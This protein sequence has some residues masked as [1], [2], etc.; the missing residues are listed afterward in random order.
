[1]TTLRVGVI[2]GGLIAQVVHLPEVA[3]LPERFELSAIAEPNRELGRAL[4]AKYG[5]ATTHETWQSL[6][7]SSEVDAVIVCAPN[8]L[9]AQILDAALDRGIPSL[10]E[11]PVCLT[12]ADAARLFERS[13]REGTHMQV[14]YMKRFDAA[15]ARLL[16]DVA[17]GGGA[18]H[19]ATAV[20]YDP[21]LGRFLDTSVIGAA[22]SF[23]R[24]AG[25]AENH[26]A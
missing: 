26:R 18:L 25:I 9:H 22:T 11:K 7:D 2:G 6:I 5:I 17:S 20:T 16:D 3:G 10:V 15:F 23:T 12:S 14:G 13:R 19:H 1:M 4:A 8:A 21:G 24:S